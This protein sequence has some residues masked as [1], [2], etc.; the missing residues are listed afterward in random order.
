MIHLM[1]EEDRLRV[2][3]WFEDYGPKRHIHNLHYGS[4]EDY[5]S[6]QRVP[7]RLLCSQDFSSV[8]C[9]FYNLL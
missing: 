2:A 7:N 4:I 6:T 9:I 8:H 3:L 5:T 1:E